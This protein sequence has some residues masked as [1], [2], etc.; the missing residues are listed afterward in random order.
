MLASGTTLTL[1]LRLF[2]RLVFAK[3]NEDGKERREMGNAGRQYEQKE[4]KG[5]KGRKGT[6]R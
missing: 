4:T 6:W 5:R 2:F 1:K 3:Q